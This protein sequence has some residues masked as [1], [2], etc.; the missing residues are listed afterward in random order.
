MVETEPGSG[1]VNRGSRIIEYG[2]H[3]R[4][5][6]RRRALALSIRDASLKSLQKQ[7]GVGHAS[8]EKLKEDFNAIFKSNAVHDRDLPEFRREGR[9][10]CVFEIRIRIACTVQNRIRVESSSSIALSYVRSVLSYHAQ[11]IIVTEHDMT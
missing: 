3:D 5:K 4:L 2:A 1:V 11:I 10:R 9:L 6:L 7:I 8:A